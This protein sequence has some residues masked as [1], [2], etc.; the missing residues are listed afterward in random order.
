MKHE[1]L[2]SPPDWGVLDDR[3][4]GIRT[5]WMDVRGHPVR[6]LRSD[7]ADGGR[8]QLLLHGLGGSAT[9]WLEVV[10]ALAR[11]G[12]VAAPDLPGFGETRPPRPSAARI[13]TNAQF[14]TALADTLGWDRVTVHGNSMGALI[15]TL[16]AAE[17]PELVRRLVLASPAL[18]APRKDALRVPKMALVTFAPFFVP[19]FG[20]SV[21]RRRY[22][23][24]SAD[25]LYGQTVRLVF[26]DPDRIRPPL[27]EVGI[28][29]AR[30]GKELGWRVESFSQ[31]SASIVEL[32][33]GARRVVAAID[34]IAAP[35]LVVWGDRDRLIGRA[36]VEG[37]VER[38]PDWDL[39]ILPDVGHAPMLERP[40]RYLELVTAWLHERGVAPALAPTAG[41]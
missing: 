26:G 12:P 6:V 29:N 21:F 25:E 13:P 36:V 2:P 8:P 23:R 1:A 32:L 15:A 17:R 16:V 40:D 31:A 5:E 27:R 22:A 19:A 9:N 34:R 28:A 33:L 11:F 37:L 10:R 30:R 7:G 20:E 3:W 38:R 39:E 35:V 18:P 24:T 14:V 4:A 41:A